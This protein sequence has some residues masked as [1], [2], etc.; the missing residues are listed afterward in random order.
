[1]IETERLIIRNFKLTD[2]E[3]LYEVIKT[4]KTTEYAKL[5]ERDTGH[6]WPDAR[7]EYKGIIEWF[8]KGDDFLAVVLNENTQVIGLIAKEKHKNESFG[9]GYVFHSDFLGEGYA[10]EAGSAVVD[11]IFE[12]LETGKIITGT[13]IENEPSNN[14]L[15]KLGFTS[16]GKGKYQLTKEEWLTQ[17]R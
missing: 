9:F 14:L 8:S 3:Q 13:P 17:S 15:K 1:M 7:E 5:E 11:F 6:R 12:N 4:Y 16:I 10:T 2:E